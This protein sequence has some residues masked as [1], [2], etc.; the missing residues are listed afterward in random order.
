MILLDA[1]YIVPNSGAKVLL[2][3]LINN[4]ENTDEEVF[5]LFDERLYSEVKDVKKPN[6]S[7]FLKASLK[8]R[9]NFYKNNHKSFSTILCFGNLPPNISTKA[10]VYTYFHQPLFL[11]IPESFSLKRK[12]LFTLKTKI[13]NLFKKNTDFWIVQNDEVKE[14]LSKKY[15]IA[16]G[17]ILILP[18]YPP[19]PSAEEVKRDSG[20]Y[21]YASQASDHKN[22]EKLIE[23]FS[24]HYNKTRKGKLILT[25]ANYHESIYRLIQEK[26]KEGI[27]IEN[28][29]FV[30]REELAVIYKSSEYAIYP[31]LAESFGLGIVEAL[32]NGCK[33]IGADLPYTYAVCEPSIV[34]NPYDTN[35]IVEALSLSL[36]K[37]VKPSKAK[38]KNNI[39]ELIS[40]LK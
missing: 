30:N 2:D 28:I 17:E 27:N 3:Y 13:L 10:K 37:D 22:H 6:K 26:Q 35:S 24:L 5:Y 7:I 34:F 33:I 15:S 11:K 12:I 23:A 38:V 31:S 16:S 21:I 25:I 4:L 9:Y 20:N 8:N 40:L 19:F 36:Q 14:K 32:E 29:G 1:L 18:F 39:N